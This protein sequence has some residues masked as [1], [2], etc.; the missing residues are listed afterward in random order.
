MVIVIIEAADG[1]F[2]ILTTRNQLFVGHAGTEYALLVRLVGLVTDNF[3]CSSV[4]LIVEVT[5]VAQPGID[6]TLAF[7]SSSR[8]FLVTLQPLLVLFS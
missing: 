8:L 1:T 5:T 6:A 2:A 7:D 4:C 3:R